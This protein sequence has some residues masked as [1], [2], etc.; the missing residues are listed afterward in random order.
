MTDERDPR[1]RAMEPRDLPAVA[2]FAARLVRMHHE[3][4]AQRFLD[5]PN[6]ERGYARY[7]ASELAS[8]EVVLL[9]AELD[10]QII[11]YL[12]ARLEPRSYNELLDACGKIHDIFVDEAARGKGAGEA[13]LRE[14][15]KRLTERGA[16]RVVLLTAVANAA[17]QRLF[18]RVGFRNT[19][20]EMTYE[21]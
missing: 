21:L 8:E 1:V 3:L 14:G 5:L 2:A 9:V 11:G 7:L 13:L 10:D 18:A 12:Y 19:M 17:A 6:A 16:P 15:M 4:D 20:L